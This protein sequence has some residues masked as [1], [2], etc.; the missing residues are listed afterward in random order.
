VDVE[1]QPG[2]LHLPAGQV[3]HHRVEVGTQ[4]GRLGD[5]NEGLGEMAIPSGVVHR[6]SASTATGA[7]CGNRT[8]RW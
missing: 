8:M 5:R 1:V 7:S 6:A 2:L 4:P 3:Q